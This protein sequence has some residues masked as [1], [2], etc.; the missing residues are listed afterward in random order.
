[1]SV[2]IKGGTSNILADVD[3][4]NNLKVNTPTTLTGAGYVVI[5]GEVDEGTYTGNRIVRPIDVSQDYRLRTGVDKIIWQDTFNHAVLNNSKYIGVTSTMTITL[6]NGF[7]NLNAGNAVASGNVARVQTFKSFSLF[8]TYPLYIDFKAK[9]SATLQIGNVIEFGL[10]IATGTATPTDG[11]FFRATGGQLNAVTNNNGVEQVSA[12]NY[13]INA[14]Q[15]YHLAITIGQDLCTFWINDSI[16]ASIRTASGLGSPCQSNSLPLLLRNYNSGT[17]STAVQLN[18]SQLGITLGDMDSGKDWGTVMATNGQSS[19]LGPDGIAATS[20][21]TANFVNSTGP[22]SVT[23]SNTLSGYLTLGGQFQFNAPAG[24]ET[25]YN[26]FTYLVPAGTAAIP[27]KTLIITGVKIDTW[28]SG[29]AVATT[30]TVLQW[31]IGIGSTAIS[32]AT[33]DSAT[34]GTRAPRRLGLGAQSAIVGTPIG[35]MFTPNVDVRFLTPLMVESGTYCHIIVKVPTGTATA[36][37]VIRGIVSI[38]GYFE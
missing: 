17:P 32:L 4:N 7:L 36:S 37:Q 35:G 3:I 28:N 6:A 26:I 22:G 33:A 19:M 27:A 24:A 30:A 5:A 14:N 16:V 12:I 13:T 11:V 10:G 29:A 9:F 25:D 23:L 2:I 20:G 8:N 15:V 38:N 21:Q 1:M 18:I 34:A 31:V